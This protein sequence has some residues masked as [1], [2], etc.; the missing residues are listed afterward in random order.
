MRWSKTKLLLESLL[1]ENLIKRLKIHSTRYNASIGEPQR[2][3]ITLDKTVIFNASSQ[4]FLNKHDKFWEDVKYKTD[5]PFPECLYECYPEFMGKFS[6]GDYSMLVLEQRNIFNVDRVYKAFVLFPN[7]SIDEAVCCNNVIIQ[8]L[9]LIDKR[10]GKRKL[11]NLRFT[12]DTH[13]IIKKF[14]TIRCDAEGI[15]SFLI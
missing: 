12:P 15:R 2:I 6:D 9:A 3:W 8:A 1:C 7:L 11:R 13:P 10:L 4:Y 5:K 14:Y